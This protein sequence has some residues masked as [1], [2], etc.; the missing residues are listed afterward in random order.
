MVDITEQLEGLRRA[1]LEL[2]QGFEQSKALS[3]AELVDALKEAECALNEVR[4][5]TG[6]RGRARHVGSRCCSESLPPAW[7]LNAPTLRRE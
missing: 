1:S 5:A 6:R 2:A 7:I 4:H 3:G